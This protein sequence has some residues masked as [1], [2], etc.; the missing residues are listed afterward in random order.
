MHV[1]L[2]DGSEVNA[3]KMHLAEAAERDTPIAAVMAVKKAMGAA[4]GG[5]EEHLEVEAMVVE[6]EDDDDEG[7][8]SSSEAVDAEGGGVATASCAEADNASLVGRAVH[9]AGGPHSGLRG[10]VCG[11]NQAWMHVRLDDGSE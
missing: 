5:A 7:D 11:F 3:R 4:E 6:E 10:V 1:R 8:A 9:V 2:D